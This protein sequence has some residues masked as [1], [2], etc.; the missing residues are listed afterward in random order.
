MPNTPCIVEDCDR[1]R[2]SKIGW[3]QM[4]ANRMR[5]HGSLNAPPDHRI[6]YPHGTPQARI[7]H[8]R[9]GEDYCEK[10]AVRI[11]R[12]EAEKERD[13][14]LR[15]KKREQR[16]AREAAGLSKQKRDVQVRSAGYGNFEDLEAIPADLADWV[17]T[18]RI[19]ITRRRRIEAMA[20]R[21][22]RQRFMAAL[23]TPEGQAMLAEIQ[24]RKS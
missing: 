4:H 8:K 11:P 10:C 16:K 15:D 13:Q 22:R 1:P 14:R 3:C 18:R 5:R 20:R 17:R 19:R 6:R 2:A 21:T 23:S 12:T 7:R 9:A 24:G